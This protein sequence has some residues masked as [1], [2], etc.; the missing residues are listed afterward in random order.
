MAK[1]S[2]EQQ[3][4][5]AFRK[6]RLVVACLW[7]ESGAVGP[8]Y[9]YD[10]P[11]S[12]DQLLKMLRKVMEAVN[13]QDLHEYPGPKV[14]DWPLSKRAV[15]FLYCLEGSSGKECEMILKE[16][17]WQK[18][19]TAEGVKV[20]GT[21]DIQQLYEQQMAEQKALIRK[22]QEEAAAEAQYE[23]EKAA[24]AEARLVIIQKIEHLLKQIQSLRGSQATNV[25]TYLLR[26]YE[27]SSAWDVFEER[28][29][30]G[31][32]RNRDR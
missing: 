6:S 10:E 29:K 19:E 17:G 22:A 9:G 27:N 25:L 32:I 24:A 21:F 14:Y 8:I 16:L 5:E 3:L 31:L 28:L 20:S 4:E 15:E 26:R 7:P 2:M 23:G 13:P 1:K 12:Y 11:K 18:E 30:A